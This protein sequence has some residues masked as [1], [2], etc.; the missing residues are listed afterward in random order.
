MLKITTIET[1]TAQ[2][3]VLEG[4]LTGPWIPHLS[5]HWEEICREHPERKFIVDLNGV[6]RIDRVGEKAL[7]TMKSKGAEFLASGILMKHLLRR[8]EK[9]AADGRL[10]MGIA[11]GDDFAEMEG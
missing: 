3:L 2:K 7:A 10:R 1:P 4:R 6:T 8:M 9:K 11:I 5:S